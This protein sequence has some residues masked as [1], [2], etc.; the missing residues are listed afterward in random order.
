MQHV[1]HSPHIVSS[2]AFA[3]AGTCCIYV[4]NQP[5]FAAVDVFD[6]FL[7][8]VPVYYILWL[9]YPRKANAAY[10]Y[11]QHELLGLKDMKVPSKL[12]RILERLQDD[13]LSKM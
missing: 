11:L 13:G 7:L 9:S 6:A 2:D 1:V 5:C 4:D 12:S 8:L 10:Q 3:S